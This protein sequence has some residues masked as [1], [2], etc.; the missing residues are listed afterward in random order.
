L[1]KFQGQNTCSL[2]LDTALGIESE[3]HVN[4]WL[5]GQ[6]G[7]ACGRWLGLAVGF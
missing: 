5:A 2:D 4:Q 1:F 7:P 3:L 6:T